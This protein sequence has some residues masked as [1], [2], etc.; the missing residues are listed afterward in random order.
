[1]SGS[2]SGDPLA[3]RLVGSE[4]NGPWQALWQW[5]LDGPDDAESD[6]HGAR[7][8]DE[9]HQENSKGGPDIPTDSTDNSEEVTEQ[10][11]PVE[12]S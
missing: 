9:G 7:T 1:M 6:T 12:G 4:S 5:L 10:R 11:K 2:N 3:L 8:R